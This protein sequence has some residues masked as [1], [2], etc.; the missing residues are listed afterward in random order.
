MDYLSLFPS[1]SRG[2]PRFMALAAAVL[3]QVTDLQALISSMES[4]FSVASAVGVQ[5]DLLGETFHIPRLP[6][7]TEEEYQTYLQQRLKL[8]RWT[9]MNEDVDNVLPENA[10][11]SDNGDGTVTVTP[12][13]AV[14]PV[15]AGI[16]RTP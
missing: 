9:G 3:R 11:M 14:A 6:G 1:A 5:L 16:S 2:K 15:P 4:G 12:S 13:D 7:Q 8:Y 10:T